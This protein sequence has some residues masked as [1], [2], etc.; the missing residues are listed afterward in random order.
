M[1]LSNNP[2]IHLPT[3]L[4]IFTPF[5]SQSIRFSRSSG[6]SSACSSLQYFGKHKRRSK[7]HY[8][9]LSLLY[10]LRLGVWKWIK[11]VRLLGW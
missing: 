3:N 5:F 4:S 1:A 10:W 9:Y 8:I 2:H 6:P 7:K 11:I